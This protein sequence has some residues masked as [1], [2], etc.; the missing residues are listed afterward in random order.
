MA[1]LKVDKRRTSTYG[2]ENKKTNVL[3]IETPLHIIL[4]KTCFSILYLICKFLVKHR[5][6][7][8]QQ[9]LQLFL[10][11]KLKIHLTSRSEDVED[12]KRNTSIEVLQPMENL[13]E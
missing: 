3:A 7:Q 10:F 12:I 6:M 1:I 5:I 11:P 2:P 4:S 8:V 9:A 13:L